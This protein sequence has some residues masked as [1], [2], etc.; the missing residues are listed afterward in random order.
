[1]LLAEP[2]NQNLRYVQMN[3]S[4]ADI[5]PTKRPLTLGSPIQRMLRTREEF[6][7]LLLDSHRPN[8]LIM[9]VGQGVCFADDCTVSKILD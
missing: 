1:M 2:C 4:L 9:G 3:P 7:S 8:V 5:T 6:S